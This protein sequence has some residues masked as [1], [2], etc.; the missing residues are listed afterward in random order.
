MP[1]LI[2]T[3]V[4]V[5]GTALV[6]KI[7]L[8]FFIYIC[9]ILWDN[10]RT[11]NGILIFPTEQKFAISF[12]RSWKD[13]SFW[14][15]L[16]V[17]KA[18]T[19][20]G[21]SGRLPGREPNNSLGVKVPKLTRSQKPRKAVE[22]LLWNTLLEGYPGARDTGSSEGY[23]SQC[24]QAPGLPSALQTGSWVARSLQALGS[25][26]AGGRQAWAHQPPTK[27]TAKALNGKM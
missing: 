22:P 20:A 15:F 17:S 16:N 21:S 24:V 6:L 2:F 9:R 8:A 25:P 23:D 3:P 4:V 14:L 12:R 5:N 11:N 7:K 18:P 27:W 19:P 26:A 10:S 1:M 13:I